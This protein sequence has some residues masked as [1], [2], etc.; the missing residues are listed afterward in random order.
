MLYHTSPEP[1]TSI[2]DDGLFGSFLFFSSR[3]YH[4]GPNQKIVY[5]IDDEDLSIIEASQLFYQENAADADHVVQAAMEEFGVDED[6]AE[7]IIDGTTSVFEL[8]LGLPMENLGELA[9]DSQY[10]TAKAAEALG[11][12]GVEVEDEQGAAYMI[13]MTNRIGDLVE[14]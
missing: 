7:N 9:W 4:M 11:F 3:V 14:Q 5:V 13:D 2:S 6:T 10:Y 12:D 8:D 1:I